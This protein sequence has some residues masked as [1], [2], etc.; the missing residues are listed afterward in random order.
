MSK[1]KS[2]V[3]SFLKRAATENTNFVDAFEKESSVNSS[4]PHLAKVALTKSEEDGLQMLLSGYQTKDIDDVQITRDLN[5]LKE[6]NLNIKGLTKQNLILHGECISKAQ[7]VLK[8]YKRGAFTNWLQ[9]TYNNRSTPYSLLH[10]YE[11]YKQ[12]TEK[13]KILFEKMP[14][15]AAYLLG[16]RNGDINQKIDL[17]TKYHEEPQEII[18]DRIRATFPLNKND[19]RGAKNNNQ[20]TVEDILDL[21]VNLKKK[22]QGTLGSSVKNMLKDIIKLANELSK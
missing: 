11:L 14:S 5:Q 6:V 20:K 17:I 4:M 9:A 3:K 21:L 8:N 16:S 13:E 1:T 2:Q 7:S 22:K 10:Y 15:R 12:L 19:K 18:I